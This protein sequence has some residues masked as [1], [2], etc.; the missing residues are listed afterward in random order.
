MLHTSASVLSG[1]ERP[2]LSVCGRERVDVAMEIG[3]VGRGSGD[4]RSEEWVGG[5][6]GSVYHRGCMTKGYD[7][8]WALVW[9]NS[10]TLV[11]V[12]CL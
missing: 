9:F 12:F 10:Y 3:G 1:D 5:G 7:C 4:E 11:I 2:P 6:G 8:N